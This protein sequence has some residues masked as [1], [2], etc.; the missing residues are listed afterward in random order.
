MPGSLFRNGAG[1]PVA[2]ARRRSLV[3]SLSPEGL[4]LSSLFGREEDVR[5]IREMLA[6]EGVRLLTLTG[7]GGVGKTRLALHVAELVR[8]AFPG[9]VHTTFLAGIRHPRLVLAEIARA[10]GIVESNPDVMRTRLLRVLNAGEVL[11]VIDNFEHL[12]I[13]APEITGLLRACPRLTVMVTSRSGLEVYGEHV[14]PVPPLRIESGSVQLFANRARAYGAGF[15]LTDANRRIVE[16]I[17]SRLDGLPLAIELAAARLNVL[18]LRELRDRLDPRLPE[19]AAS[20]GDMPD[21]LRTMTSAIRWSYDLLD[22]MDQVV[23]RRLAVFENGCRVTAASA[24]MTTEIPDADE[25]M[26]RCSRIASGSL[27]IR[28]E[29]A[30]GERRYSMLEIIREFGI[31][32]LAAHGE[33]AE[34]RDGH[35]RYMEEFLDDAVRGLNRSDQGVWSRRLDADHAN[36]EAAMAWTLETGDK[37]RAIGIANGMWLHWNIQGETSHALGWLTDVMALEQV[38]SPAYET[39]GWFVLGILSLHVGDVEVAADA[40]MRARA[41]AEVDGGP[42][43]MAQSSYIQGMVAN[44]RQAW[45]DADRA[46]TEARHWFAV[47]EYAAGEAAVLNDHG[48]TAFLQRDYTTARERFEAALA[49]GRRLNSPRTMSMGLHNLGNLATDQG[50]YARAAQLHIECMTLNLAHG[51]EWHTMLP[52]IGLVRIAAETGRNMLAAR[53]TGVAE[54]RLNMP[55]ISLWDWQLPQDYARTLETTREILASDSA[56]EMI[57]EGRG[58]TLEES[59]DAARELLTPATRTADHESG[60]TRREREVLDLVVTGMSDREMAEALFISV[61]TVQTHMRRIF[62]KLDVHSRTEAIAEAHRRNLV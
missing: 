59:I 57:G 32:Q 54:A 25:V 62:R 46:L 1:P 61:R 51:D 2:S 19:L 24:M 7:P 4:P 50:D 16:D 27:M 18:S 26:E 37:E 39:S 8:D 5:T 28:S 29:D 56:R 43:P 34:T 60:F 20:A 31:S 10:C 21:R 55:G 53:L 49:I 14:Y 9:G 38:V 23:F 30:D 52:L 33:L 11:L 47:L 22:P 42:W 58:M 3:Q 35:A 40:A 45:R 12:V 36:I 6:R 13:A 44:A 15:R 48:R 41:A 17:C